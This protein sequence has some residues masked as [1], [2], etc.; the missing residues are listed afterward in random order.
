M[1]TRSQYRMVAAALLLFALTNYAKAG[2]IYD[3][4]TYN[5]LQNG[6]SLSGTITTDGKIGALSASDFLSYS[7]TISGPGGPFFL[8]GT[9]L[10]TQVDGT[11]LGS[12]TQI[13]IP[14]NTLN[15]PSNDLALSD[16]QGAAAIAYGNPFIN[17]DPLVAP[18]G[19]YYFAQGRDQDEDDPPG[20][21]LGPII[22]MNFSTTGIALPTDAS[23]VVAAV[24]EP[25]GIALMLPGIVVLALYGRARRR[26]EAAARRRPSPQ[27]YS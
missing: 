14:Q 10:S 9:S 5:G 4:Q 19:F 12:A 22:W 21:P 13:T 18:P 17:G 15:G 20:S 1:I 24:P 8:N 3:I 16:S 7:I 23:W 6:F 26:R 25:T 11:V 2:M 27:A